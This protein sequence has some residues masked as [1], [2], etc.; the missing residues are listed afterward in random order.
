MASQCKGTCL[1]F[2]DKLF[3]CLNHE[4]MEHHNIGIGQTFNRLQ[5]ESHNRTPIF[6]NLNIPFVRGT[7]YTRCGSVGWV[8]PDSL[9]RVTGAPVQV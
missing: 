4:L 7:R 6:D 5:A 9:A 8:P 1:P 3:V 2:A